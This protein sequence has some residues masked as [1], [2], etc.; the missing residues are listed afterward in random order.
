MA[1]TGAPKNDTANSGL[2]TTRLTPCIA[3]TAAA[4]AASSSPHI[5]LL[6]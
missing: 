3:S 2:R 6:L 4:G 5:T 1:A